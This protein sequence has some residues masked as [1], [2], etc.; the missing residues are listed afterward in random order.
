[1]NKYYEES[2]LVYPKETPKNSDDQ[3][4]GVGW[5]V[6]REGGKFY[7][8]YISGQ[9]AGRENKIEISESDFFDMRSGELTFDKVCRKY[10]VN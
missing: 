3:F 9:L 7:F 10:G 8:S 2:E 1:M 5:D 4:F 6:A